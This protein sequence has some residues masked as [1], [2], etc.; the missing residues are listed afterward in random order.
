V[1]SAINSSSSPL[2]CPTSKYRHVAKQEEAGLDV[3]G[4][5]FKYKNKKAYYFFEC[6]KCKFK[7]LQKVNPGKYKFNFS[8][9]TTSIA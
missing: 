9:G 4:G 7:E 2:S 5:L 1:T 3:A 6:D 8:L